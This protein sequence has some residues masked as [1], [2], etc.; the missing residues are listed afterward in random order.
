MDKHIIGL[1]PSRDEAERAIN[2]IHR[3]CK[4]KKE[5]ISYV[6][7]DVAGE[8]KEGDVDSAAGMT[9]AEG[10][11]TGAGVGAAVGAVAGLAVVAGVMPVI[12]PIFAAGPL[13]SALGLT[14]AL[15][16]TAAGAVTGAVAG[17]LIGALV[18]LGVDEPKAKE[19][20]DRVLAGDILVAAHI[21]DNDTEEEKVR[22]VMLDN[23]ASQVEGYEVSV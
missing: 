5:E 4:V 11:K 15:G 6:Y 9:P 8:V 14:G 3:D 7:K 21:K 17:G 1:F 22:D 18:G 12:G 13:V 20:Q 16:T 2:Q 10:A 19:Y 23:N